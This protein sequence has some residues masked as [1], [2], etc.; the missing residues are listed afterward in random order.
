MVGSFLGGVSIICTIGIQIK[1][2]KEQLEQKGLGAWLQVEGLD[3][4]DQRESKAKKI[5]EAQISK[6]LI[7]IIDMANISMNKGISL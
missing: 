1:I 7:K 4:Q 3:N 5:L 2:R 6:D